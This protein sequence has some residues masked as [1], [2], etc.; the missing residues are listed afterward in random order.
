MRLIDYAN[1]LLMQA[2][3]DFE[4]PESY[5]DRV[6]EYMQSQF[7]KNPTSLIELV[8]QGLI[9]VKTIDIDQFCSI[10]ERNWGKH[11][12]EIKVLLPEDTESLSSWDIS[13]QLVV[14]QKFDDM[15]FTYK[16]KMYVTEH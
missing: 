1:T 15:G 5:I 6:I 4:I 7:K 3:L 13:K 16:I 9:E 8:N 10:M 2:L 11:Y 14:I 12:I